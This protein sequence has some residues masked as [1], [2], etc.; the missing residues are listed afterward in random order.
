M[1]KEEIIE[2][3]KIV[4]KTITMNPTIKQSELEWVIDMAMSKGNEGYGEEGRMWSEFL[5]YKIDQSR[6]DTLNEVLEKIKKLPSY[7]HDMGAIKFPQ[8]SKRL[9]ALEDLE[10]LI[11]DMKGEQ[12]GRN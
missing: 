11:N 5:K 9:K 1:K 3:Q 10:Q 6:Q 7:P 12:D 4:D 8:Y 2:C